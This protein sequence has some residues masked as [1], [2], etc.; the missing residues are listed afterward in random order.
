MPPI[1][2]SPGLAPFTCLRP[3]VAVKKVACRA[4]PGAA[5]PW[6]PVRPINTRHWL[7]AIEPCLNGRDAAPVLCQQQLG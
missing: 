1:L 4:E 5:A 7:F 6:P 2:P 3:F